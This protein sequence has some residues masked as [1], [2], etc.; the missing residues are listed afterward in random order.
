MIAG[1]A[2]AEPTTADGRLLLERIQAWDGFCGVESIGCAAYM[3]VEYR[4]QRELLDPRLGLDLARE[5]IGGATAWVALTGLL[6]RPNDAW[7]DDPTTAERED[8]GTVATRA[9]DKAA[10]E[11][12]AALGSPVR[13]TWGRL[14]TVTFQEATFGTSGVGPLEWY[15]NIGPLQ[16]PGAAGALNATNY[17]LRRAYPD[18]ADPAFRPVG[19]DR[20]FDVT[21][22]P[23]YRQLIDFGALD[24]MR[25]VQ[26]TGNAGNP[27]DHHYGDL[28]GDWL[29]GR[30]VPL[31]FSP[32][33]IAEHAV[34]T[35]T[36]VPASTGG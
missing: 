35:L 22:L 28:V 2:R 24:G 7:W 32:A 26:T 16:A 19:I 23:S 8:V 4:L 12:R 30:T 34:T 20:V 18:P 25:I 31:W 14:H 21:N 1:L 3:A 27:F 11:L 29:A 5:Y 36:L 15:F 33:A 10:A 13:W 9:T 17:R 6:G